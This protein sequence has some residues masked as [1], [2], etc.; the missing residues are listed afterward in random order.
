MLPILIENELKVNP[1]SKTVDTK[2]V[3]LENLRSKLQDLSKKA[4][5]I[6]DKFLLQLIKH[7]RILVILDNLSE[8]SELTRQQIEVE[9][10][11]FNALIITSRTEK[12][13]NRIC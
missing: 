3:L 9:S 7:R 6:S 10:A 8:M 1:S 11:D 4:Q 2:Q 5:P 12:S 13:I